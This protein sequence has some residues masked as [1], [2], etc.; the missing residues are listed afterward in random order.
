MTKI[1]I[2]GLTKPSDYAACVAAGASLV[3]LVFYPASPRHLSFE[4]A[5][6]LVENRQSHD[7]SE[8][9]KPA[10]VALTVN[11]DDALLA[12][13]ISACHPNW[14]QLHGHESA[15]RCDHIR[16]KFGLPLIKAITVKS[17]EDIVAASA[18]D[19]AI[20]MFLFDA[21]TGNPDRPG[22]MG[23]RFDWRLLSKAEMKRP[24]MLAG[25][26]TAHNVAAAI[27]QTAAL[28]VD[29]SSGVESAPGIK[30]HA[31]INAFVSAAKLG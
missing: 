28:F 3:G 12:D 14:L 5:A 9:N 18:Y 23:A 19:N 31:A 2:C 22:G 16:Q 8:N 21:A 4:S 17:A 11:A 27:K 25:G 26:L 24:W 7:G 10:I 29:V 20:D 13:I 30:D 1:K 15:A 6:K